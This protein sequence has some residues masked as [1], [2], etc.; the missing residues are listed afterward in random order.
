MSRILRQL[1]RHGIASSRTEC[2]TQDNRPGTDPSATT[3]DRYRHQHNDDRTRNPSDL[4][5]D[6]H[7]TNAC[8]NRGALPSTARPN[9]LAPR[10]ADID[11]IEPVSGITL[12]RPTPRRANTCHPFGEAVATLRCNVAG[13]AGGPAC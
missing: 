7:R 11:A 12:S 6:R 13:D 9:S 1:D 8:E 5:L 2:R 10:L 4:D 3:N